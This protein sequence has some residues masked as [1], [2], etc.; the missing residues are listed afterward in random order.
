MDSKETSQ[1]VCPVCG[2][3]LS[4]HSFGEIRGDDGKSWSVEYTSVI[5]PQTGLK[6][7]IQAKTSTPRDISLVI[8]DPEHGKVSCIENETHLIPE[9]LIERIS[10]MTKEKR[11]RVPMKP[12]SG[13]LTIFANDKDIQQSVF[14]YIDEW[15]EKSYPTIP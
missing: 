12:V 4:R 5:H 1:F 7:T 14:D 10:L 3:Y 11:N 15:Y 13:V 8:E 6:A 2:G 9:E